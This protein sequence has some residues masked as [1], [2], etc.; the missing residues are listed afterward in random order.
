[1]T[2]PLVV[3]QKQ[4]L[5]SAPMGAVLCPTM[6][7]MAFT[8]Q[9][10]SLSIYVRVVVT[11]PLGSGVVL[12]RECLGVFQRCISWHHLHSITDPAHQPGFSRALAWSPCGTNKTFE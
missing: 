7:L 6:D 3:L 8:A 5:S 12:L 9:D 1:M 11:K 2:E 4:R 10:A